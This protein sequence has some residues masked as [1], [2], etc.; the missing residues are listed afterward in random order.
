MYCPR[1]SE[2]LVECIAVFKDGLKS[3]TPTSILVNT[4]TML[5]DGYGQ[6]ICP[7]CDE[8]IS[9]LFFSEDKMDE[10]LDD[11]QKFKDENGSDVDFAYCPF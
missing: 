8:D 10:L 5:E 11:K 1:C 6:I 2:K 4:L 3:L 9:I 7:H